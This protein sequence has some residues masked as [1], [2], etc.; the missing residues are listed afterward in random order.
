MTTHIVIEGETLKRIARHMS[1]HHCVR[2]A[3]CPVVRHIEA[4]CF[5]R[6]ARSLAAADRLASTNL[7]RDARSLAEWTTR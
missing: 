3:A 1:R 4:A 5:V 6:D 2:I 7:R